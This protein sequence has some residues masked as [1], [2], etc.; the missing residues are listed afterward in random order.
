M[1]W[2]R[3]AVALAMSGAL[4]GSALVL[5]PQA[6]TAAP[7]PAVAP[8]AQCPAGAPGLAVKVGWQTVDTFFLAMDTYITVANCR[9]R[10]RYV[11]IVWNSLKSAGTGLVEQDAEIRSTLPAK[12]GNR[13][14]LITARKFLRALYTEAATNSGPIKGIALDDK[15]SL[16]NLMNCQFLMDKTPINVSD[17]SF[18][19]R[20]EPLDARLRVIPNV[21]AASLGP[22]ACGQPIGT[23]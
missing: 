5:T 2:G 10:I 1:V 3:H 22:F 4:L 16:N 21:G 9:S 6:V 12:N 20:V 7:A 18:T 14:Y 8:Q 13:R 17:Y 19:I 23:T 11:R 15:K